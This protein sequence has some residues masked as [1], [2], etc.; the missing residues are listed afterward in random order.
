LYSFFPFHLPNF[1]NEVFSQTF[2]KGLL[3]KKPLNPFSWEE[4]LYQKKISFFLSTGFLRLFYLPKKFD[5]K[6]RSNP[7]PFRALFRL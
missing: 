3:R 7:S 5:Q 2:F 6:L 4:K 1:F